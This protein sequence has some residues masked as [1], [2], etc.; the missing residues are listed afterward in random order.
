MD[1]FVDVEDVIPN[2][3]WFEVMGGAVRRGRVV[4]PNEMERGAKVR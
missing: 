3:E 4:R 1:E 2:A